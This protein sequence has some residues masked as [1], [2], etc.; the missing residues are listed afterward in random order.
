MLL[1]FFLLVCEFQAHFDVP[2]RGTAA[3]LNGCC[4]VLIEKTGLRALFLS[5]FLSV[6]GN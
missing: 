4:T 3:K 5:A 1:R 2:L 6:V